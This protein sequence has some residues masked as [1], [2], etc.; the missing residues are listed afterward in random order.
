M[1]KTIKIILIAV[2]AIA[3]LFGGY[4][5]YKY[6]TSPEY[7]I[8][9]DLTSVK[10]KTLQWSI[11]ALNHDIYV[12]ES[13]NCIFD[14]YKTGFD[15]TVGPTGWP[16]GSD[17]KWE[18]ALYESST[19]YYARL[20]LHEYMLWWSWDDPYLVVKI[21]KA[22]VNGNPA[23]DEKFRWDMLWT[24]T[25]AT[26]RSY[27]YSPY[28]KNVKIESINGHTVSFGRYGCKYEKYLVISDVNYSW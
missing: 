22:Y 23:T 26:G 12:N 25:H 1:K 18:I 3:V 4:A 24:F 28:V 13:L 20:I 2:A 5:A 27:N 19:S 9:P 14:G 16:V 15:V 10:P 8:T 11:G 17:L 6:S 7:A 21:P